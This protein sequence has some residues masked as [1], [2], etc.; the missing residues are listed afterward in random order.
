MKTLYQLALQAVPK[1]GFMAETFLVPHHPAARDL[2]TLQYTQDRDRYR[3][4]HRVLFRNTI[5]ALKLRRWNTYCHKT[6]WVA[7]KYQK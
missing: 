1:P 3:E 6:E 7:V 2:Q 5:N 4:E